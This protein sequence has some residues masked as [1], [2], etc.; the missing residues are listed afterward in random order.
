MVQVETE[1]AKVVN[2]K[3]QVCEGQCEEWQG[4]GGK[5]KVKVK[6]NKG[7]HGEGTLGR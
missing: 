6:Y 7:C 2:L 1:E 4:E 3:G 5:V